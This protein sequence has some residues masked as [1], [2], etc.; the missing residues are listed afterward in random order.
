MEAGHVEHLNELI[1]HNKASPEQRSVRIRYH[2]L[3]TKR[4]VNRAVS[5]LAL[6]G[7]LLVAFDHKRKAVRTFR[8]DRIKSMEKTA[9]WKG[10]E[11]RATVG[12]HA[13]ADV[14]ALGTLMAPSIAGLSG[15]HMS[16][17]SKD[18]AEVAG[19]GG[20]I[21]LQAKPAMQG[22]RDIGKYVKPGLKTIGRKILT[23]GR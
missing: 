20:L 10:F 17:K 8:T 6:N 11:K 14:G 9:F 7:K 19:L 16:E 12:M 4:H 1:A 22:V 18:V 5:P 3:S 2:K 13:L 23:R 21:A 15:H